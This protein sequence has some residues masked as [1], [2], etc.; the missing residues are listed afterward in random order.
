[1]IVAADNHLP[2][3]A[4]GTWEPIR[5]WASLPSVARTRGFCSNLV[6]ELVARNCAV[7]VGMVIE[8]LPLLRGKLFKGKAFPEV[9]V[10]PV[11]APAV[12]AVPCGG[13]IPSVRP[14]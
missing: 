7:V 6:F 8:K 14:T 1:M 11:P 9:D 5:I 12:M 3:D 13:T 4:I 10:P 2:A